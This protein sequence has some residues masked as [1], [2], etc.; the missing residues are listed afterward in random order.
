MKT[1]QLAAPWPSV[2]PAALRQPIQIQSQSSTQ[3]AYGQ[4]QQSWSTILSCMGGI[5]LLSMKEAFGENQLTSSSTD[6]WTL[7]WCGVEI[8]PGMQL[9][10]GTKIFRIQ[11][12]N[13]VAER[14]VILHL[15]CL[16]LNEG[17]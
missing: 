3:D 6:I 11:A 13:N 4:P 14:N 2:N 10:F 7:R 8:Q 15:L 9:L 17:S 12:V 5:N 1:A 16:S